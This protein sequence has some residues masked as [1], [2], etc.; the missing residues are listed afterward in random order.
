[1]TKCRQRLS[2]VKRKSEVL[3]ND[4]K[5][6]PNFPSALFSTGRILHKLCFMETIHNIKTYLTI[7]FNI[8]EARY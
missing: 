1:M 3:V 7:L 2:L 4:A 6:S 5:S 8:V